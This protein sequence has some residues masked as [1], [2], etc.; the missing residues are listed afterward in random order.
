MHFLSSSLEKLVMNMKKKDDSKFIFTNSYFGDKSYLL[1]QKGHF[2]YD[3]FTDESKFHEIELPS[4]EKFY[5]TLNDKKL[6]D[7]EYLHCQ[8]IWH[9]FKMV[10]FEEYHDVYLIS[11]VLLLCDICEEFCNIFF[12]EFNLDPFHYPTLPSFGYDLMLKIGNV[13]LDKLLDIDQYLFCQKG[14]RGGVTTTNHRYWKAN[15][16]M[17]EDYDS[18]K[19]MSY[20][21]FI[22]K[23]AL[24]PEAMKQML[25]MK[26]LKWDEDLDKFKRNYI[27]SLSDTFTVAMT[28]L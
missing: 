25:P 2:P 6:S 20:L 16:P 4:Q 17:L 11:D 14:I 5:D 9:E 18:T 19:P 27:L 12:N 21:Y 7:E 22:D 15:N 8:K 26:N 23:N 24:Y 13:R 28:K 3:W 10:T 1:L